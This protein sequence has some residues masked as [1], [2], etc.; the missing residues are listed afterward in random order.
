MFFATQLNM[1]IT[2][3]GAKRFTTIEQL[4]NRNPVKFPVPDNKSIEENS[5]N[6]FDED[7]VAGSRLPFTK[8][9]GRNDYFITPGNLLKQDEFYES[10][11]KDSVFKNP[12]LYFGDNK[13]D[14]IHIKS[15]SANE[16]LATVYK[17]TAGVLIYLQN[18][19]HGWHAFIDKD[20]TT[21]APVNTSFMAIQVPAGDHEIIFRYRPQTIINAWYVSIFSFVLLV[22]IYLFLFFSKQRSTKLQKENE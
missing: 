13:T 20:Q 16:L 3:Y 21:I 18:N 8:K 15:L 6:S 1:P 12:V 4:I 22:I 5:L 10:A 19:Y 7:F 2:A 11:I 17:R 14:S 9:I